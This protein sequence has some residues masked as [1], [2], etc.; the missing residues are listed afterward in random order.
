[1]FI[2]IGV[3]ILQII[4]IEFDRNVCNGDIDNRSNGN[5][6]KYA[7]N[8]VKHFTCDKYGETM[9]LSSISRGKRSSG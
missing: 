9:L 8:V 6:T 4:I 5:F 2:E 1:M 7:V 3:A